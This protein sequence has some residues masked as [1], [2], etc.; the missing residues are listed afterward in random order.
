MTELGK[1][2]KDLKDFIK[3]KTDQGTANYIVKE[4]REICGMVE[5]ERLLMYNVGLQSGQLPQ[6]YKK[7]KQCNTYTVETYLDG[8]QCSRC[9]N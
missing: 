1:K 3:Q 8:K 2:I 7:C 9:G 5:S 6:K 4:M